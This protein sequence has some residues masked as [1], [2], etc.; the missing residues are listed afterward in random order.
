MRV[1]PIYAAPFL[2]LVVLMLLGVSALLG[3]DGFGA[4]INPYLSLIVVQIIVYALPSVFFCR[5]RGKAYTQRLRLRFVRP[6]HLFLMLFALMAMLSGSA[7]LNLGMTALF[8]NASLSASGS[9]A[10]V[11]TGDP[12]GILYAVLALCILPALLEEFLFR[13]IIAAEYESVGV[14]CA[15]FMSA[16]VFAMMHLNAVR[17]PAYFFSGVV[18]ALTLYAT[19]SLLAPM[20]VH[21]VNNIVALW[22][23]RYL[24]SA[25]ADTEESGVLLLFILFCV[26]FVSLIFFSMSAQSIYTGYGVTNT[27]SPHVRKKKRGETGIAEAFTAPP[28]ILMVVLF[29]IFIAVS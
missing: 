25:A 3:S 22:T 4:A 15:V 20:I 17:L 19:R 6:A 11:Y 16:F 24:Y 27:P 5:L 9:Y 29:I 21:A 12:G 10:G 28:F 7:L 18:L 8:P 14:P 13:G 23:D 2:I 26:F 1:K